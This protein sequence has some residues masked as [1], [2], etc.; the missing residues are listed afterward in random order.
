MNESD[1]PEGDLAFEE[2]TVRDFVDYAET[3]DV[4]LDEIRS[5]FPFQE[6]KSIV[7]ENNAV[8]VMGD[9]G[10]ENAEVLSLTDVARPP[11]RSPYYPSKDD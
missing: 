5:M 7:Q 3:R 8:D 10:L 6:R 1:I 9:M 4:L 2:Y 11:S